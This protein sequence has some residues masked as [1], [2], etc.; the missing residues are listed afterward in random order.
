[1]TSFAAFAS[2]LRLTLPSR[3]KSSLLFAGARRVRKGLS[4]IE[5]EFAKRIRRVDAIARDAGSLLA[6]I[7]VAG[8]YGCHVLRGT[9]RRL[10]NA[11][12]VPK[13]KLRIK[14]DLE[15]NAFGQVE[16]WTVPALAHGRQSDFA[17]S[18]R[19]TYFP[20]MGWHL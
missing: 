19:L 6:R 1:M 4:G 11:L 8:T 18:F 7:V 15:L 12:P 10:L 20:K 16:L 9:L 2:A 14:D 3:P 5:A 17:D 13:G